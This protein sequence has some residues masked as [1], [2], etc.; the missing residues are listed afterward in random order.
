VPNPDNVEFYDANAQSLAERYDRITTGQALPA[1]TRIIEKDGKKGRILDIGSGAGRDAF[2]FAEHGWTVDAID[3]S[4][5]LLAQA[6]AR[7]SHP[8]VNYFFDTAPDFLNTMRCG[9]S[10]ELIVMSAFL[11][12][13]DTIERNAVLENC[14]GM[15]SGDGLLHMT[16]R[17][18]PL[19]NGRN[20]FLVEVEEIENFAKHHD[21]RI[22]YHGRTGD[23]SGLADIEW[24]NISLWR[25][26]RWAFAAEIFT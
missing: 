20:I 21:L 11:F 12:H 19:Y 14:V 17:R 10:Y 8:M 13:F 9:E 3:A 1:L 25:G 22:Q 26:E 4:V 2:W 15:L 5:S 6:K 16:L 7:H 24:D 23:S 18:G